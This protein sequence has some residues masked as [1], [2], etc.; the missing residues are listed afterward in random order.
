MCKLITS[1]GDSDDLSIGF[2]RDRGRRERELTNSKNIKDKYHL[3][4]V[5]KDVFRFAEYHNKGTYGLV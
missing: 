3:R 5:L 1:S 2:D 4:I